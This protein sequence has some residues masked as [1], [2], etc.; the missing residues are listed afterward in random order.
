MAGN[1]PNQPFDNHSYLAHFMT[2]STLISALLGGVIVALAFNKFVVLPFMPWWVA[3][4][5]T[6]LLVVATLGVVRIVSSAN[7]GD[8]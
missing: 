3:L 5:S 7:G 8:S 1:D 6:P 2:K 4:V